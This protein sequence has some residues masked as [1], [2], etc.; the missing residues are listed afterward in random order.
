MSYPFIPLAAASDFG[1]W[2][3]HLRGAD[4]VTPAEADPGGSRRQLLAYPVLM[5]LLGGECRLIRDSRLTL[6]QP[7]VLYICRPGSTMDLEAQSSQATIAVLR[8]GLYAPSSPIR[9]SSGP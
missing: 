7:G 9:F 2:T 3:L 5:A 4:I 6:M 1:S 8:I